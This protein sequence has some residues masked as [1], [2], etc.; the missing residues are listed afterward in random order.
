MDS[1]IYE[2]I[3]FSNLKDKTEEYMKFYIN[4]DLNLSEKVSYILKKGYDSQKSHLLSNINLY[5]NDESSVQII[6]NEIDDNLE[7]YNQFEAELLVNSVSSIFASKNAGCFEKHYKKL[8]LRLYKSLATEK[9]IAESILLKFFK[10][11]F[12]YFEEKESVIII[13]KEFCQTI[14]DLGNFGQNANNRR[15]SVFFCRKLIPINDKAN[16]E[17]LVSRLIRLKN[18]ADP[19]VRLE[20]SKSF[21]LLYKHSINESSITNEFFNTEILPIVKQYIEKEDKLYVLYFSIKLGLK[22]PELEKISIERLENLTKEKVI[23]SNDNKVIKDLEEFDSSENTYKFQLKIDSN[24]NQEVNQNPN[25][26][27]FTDPDKKLLL[28]FLIRVLKKNENYKNPKLINVKSNIINNFLKPSFLLTEFL[29]N[30]E[31]YYEN[32]NLSDSDLNKEFMFWLKIQDSNS[33]D[34]KEYRKDIFPSNSSSNVGNTNNFIVNNISHKR[35]SVS[36]LGSYK[37]NNTLKD[38]KNESNQP[39]TPISSYGISNFFKSQIFLNICKIMNLYCKMDK[40]N[41]LFQKLIQDMFT[42]LNSILNES[43]PDFNL[44]NNINKVEDT[45]TTLNSSSDSS[46]ISLSSSANISLRSNKYVSICL[47]KKNQEITFSGNPIKIFQNIYNIVNISKSKDNQI[48]V[49][50][51]IDNFDFIEY[52]YKRKFW[53]VNKIITDIL[54]FDMFYSFEGFLERVLKMVKDFYMESE[55]EL[56]NNQILNCHISLTVYILKHCCS[57]DYEDIFPYIEIFFMR[58]NYF[59]KKHILYFF[60]SFIERYSMYFFLKTSLVNSM[61]EFLRIENLVYLDKILDLMK[62]FAPVIMYHVEF[63]KSINY[64]LEKY[65]KAL[66]SKINENKIKN[67]QYK[68]GLCAIQEYQKFIF[69]LDNNDNYSLYVSDKDLGTIFESDL[70][71]RNCKYL[72]NKQS[73]ESNYFKY[74]IS[75]K[76]P[77][78]LDSLT[79]IPKEPTKSKSNKNSFKKSANLTL[80]KNYDKIRPFSPIEKIEKNGR[81]E[82]TDK[83]DRSEKI[84]PVA[85][86]ESNVKMNLTSKIFKNP[87]NTN[88][89]SIVNTNTTNFKTQIKSSNNLIKSDLLPLT[90]KSSMVAISKK[91]SLPEINKKEKYK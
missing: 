58:S 81:E 34:K 41:Y 77:K 57:H 39:A 88:N 31:I 53:R 14:I 82:K 35:N 21:N 25:H 15:L 11:I 51:L 89:K 74:P 5:K 91:I 71:D 24:S 22:I 79:L 23:I 6:I 50:S 33:N 17:A 40:F 7:T 18:D 28:D 66:E 44:L 80:K 69:N 59:I 75:E 65:E 56:M 61:K 72:V 52:F 49:Q 27:Q 9:N 8:I 48:T 45:K 2:V 37:S 86:F 47:E 10:N 1:D 26:N 13:S 84:N 46:I 42:N 63:E 19:N 3:T 70:D 12:D 76:K 30:L 78:K 83:F 73:T 20:I 67:K 60:K 64:E 32:L 68:K 54:S 90:R 85:L 16:N 36:N 87:I 4:E 43:D 55:S 29:N 38:N 62:M